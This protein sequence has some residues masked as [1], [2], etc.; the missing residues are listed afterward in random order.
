MFDLVPETYS[1]DARFM[2]RIGPAYPLDGGKWIC[3]DHIPAPDQPC[4]VFSLGSAGD[5]GFE[6]AIKKL[7]PHCTIHTFDCT[8][9]WTNPSTIFHPWCLGE[10]NEDKMFADKIYQPDAKKSVFRTWDT[11]MKDI[12]VQRVDVLKMDIEYFEWQVLPFLLDVP[13][14]N[15]PI[16]ILLEIHYDANTY[17][18]NRNWLNHSESSRNSAHSM[19][20]LMR[21]L[22]RLGYRTARMEYNWFGGC[23][24]EV[25]LIKD[26]YM[27]NEVLDVNSEEPSVAEPATGSDFFV[28]FGVTSLICIMVT[29]SA[30]GWITQKNQG[31]VGDV[32]FK[33]FQRNYLAV[34]TLVMCK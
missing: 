24:A 21:L 30:R 14:D 25:V 15:L 34:Y 33:M 22:D 5:F 11:I 20:K 8:G 7:V 32:G 9:N 3:T 19:V 16:Q 28:M 1:C 17:T 13:S 23:C 29:Y 4:T 31:L 2:T 6:D 12:Q 27:L 18:F 26:N 10:K